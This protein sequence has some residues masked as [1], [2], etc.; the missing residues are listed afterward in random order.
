LVRPLSELTS[1]TAAA[2]IVEADPRY[3]TIAIEPRVD[4]RRRYQL[5]AVRRAVTEPVGASAPARRQL[6]KHKQAVAPLG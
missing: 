2:R 6:A 4:E 1:I 5:R 3:V